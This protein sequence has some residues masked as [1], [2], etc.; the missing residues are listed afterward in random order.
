MFKKIKAQVKNNSFGD[1]FYMECDYLWGRSEKFS[2]W[3]S[4]LK[5]Y[6]KIY[7]AAVHMIDL[8]VWIL[9]LK[10]KEVFASGNK[11]ATKKNDRKRF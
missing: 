11:I 7:G 3:R 6:S 1:I 2:G 4:K 5:Y 8:I 10:P 9:N